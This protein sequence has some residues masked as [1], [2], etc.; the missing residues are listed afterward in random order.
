[1]HRLF[2]VLALLFAAPISAAWGEDEPFHAGIARVEV[3]AAVPFDTLIWYP[4][5]GDQASWQIGPFLLPATHGAPVAAGRFPVVLLSHGGG[6]GGGSPL[7]LSALSAAL[8]RQ[9]FVVVAPFHAKAG[10]SLRTAQMGAALGAVLSDA[11]FAPHVDPVRLGMLGFSLGGAVTLELAGAS[12]D[13]AYFAAYCAAHPEDAMSCGHA[14]G[15]THSGERLAAAKPLSLKAI[16]LLDP[17]AAPFSRDGLTAVTMPVLLFRPEDSGLPA[18]R[19]AAALRTMLPQPPV[20]EALQGGHF[21]F[22]DRCAPAVQATEPELCL[23][24]AGVDREAIHADIE[25]RIAAFFGG[26]L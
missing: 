25:R 5:D 6:L 10:L 3:P 17:L 14:P 23:D 21:I 20:Y 19:N 12:P 1:M 15:G 22:A 4:A 18:E 11:R 26:T 2:L 16:V 24:Q 8:A 7:I 9:G 13:W